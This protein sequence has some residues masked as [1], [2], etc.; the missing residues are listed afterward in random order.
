MSIERQNG[1]DEQIFVKI[2]MC[3]MTSMGMS[4]SFQKDEE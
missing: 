3:H 2:I 1:E 4:Q